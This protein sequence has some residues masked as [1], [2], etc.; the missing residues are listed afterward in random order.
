MPSGFALG[1]LKF[2]GGQEG[3]DHWREA[4]GFRICVGDAAAVVGS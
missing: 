3:R 4:E 2:E 1:G